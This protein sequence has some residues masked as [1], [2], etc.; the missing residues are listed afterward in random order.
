MDY[1]MPTERTGTHPLS[2]PS[3]LTAC[4]V[5]QSDITTDDMNVATYVRPMVIAFEHPKGII[6]RQIEFLISLFPVIH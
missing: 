1:V 4:V 5:Q 2:P 6:L 3:S